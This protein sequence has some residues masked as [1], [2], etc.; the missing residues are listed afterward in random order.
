MSADRQVT[1]GSTDNFSR[2][3]FIR[4]VGRAGGAAAA[5]HTMAAMGLLPVPGA[6]AGAPAIAPGDGTKVLILGAGIA[7][8]V[9]AYE[10]GKLGYQCRILEARGRAG[11]RNWSLRGG[12]KVE[13]TDSTQSVTWDE[14]T[15]MYFNPGP[16]RLPN[17]HQGILS[18]CRE[19]GVPVEVMINDNR[20]AYFQDDNV[21]GG[22]RL[23]ARQVVNDSRGFVAELAAKAINR[24][25][26][27][28]PISTEDKEALRA[29]LKQ[30]GAL[31]KDLVYRGSGRAGYTVPPGAGDQSGK[32]NEPIDLRQLLIS[33][34]WRD[35]RDGVVAGPMLFGEMWH[36]Q[37]TMMQPIGGMGRIGEAFA[38]RL[39]SVITCNA[40]VQQIRKTGEGVRVVWRD[41]VTGAESIAEAPHLICTIPLPVLRKIDADF[42]PDVA[43][44]LYG[45]DYV[46]AG[47]IA[48]QAERRF[49]ELDDNIYG[50]I[51]WTSRDITQMW[52]PS[53]DLH[54]Q[55]GILVGAYVWSAD[56][57]KAF[58][59]KSPAQRIADAI[60]DGEYI[61]PGYAKLVGQ[62]VSVSW[63]K[64]PFSMGGWA[65]W[66]PDGRKGAYRTLLKGDGPI[67]FAGEHMSYVTGWQE[68][69]VRSAHLVMEEI[70]RRVQ[71]KR[72]TSSAPRTELE[73]PGMNRRN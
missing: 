40:E 2:R 35:K 36:H 4:L 1:K 46:Q 47:K 44:A 27:D 18:Y 48:F 49:W 61:H 23:R 63:A 73:L 34:F 66:K 26:L 67:L 38:R 33:D 3:R 29:L 72:A 11:G 39:G 31:D 12:D 51:S 5:Y 16:A 14:G 37:A 22:K 8:M 59:A 62:G 43:K 68:G 32:P 42:S 65:E 13:E 55:K 53:A 52:Y 6:Y 71:E 19:L 57:C 28:D 24:E 58:A 7:G 50:G 64:I 25:T 15:N 30:F 70:G 9:A 45:V 41:R 56:I 21:Y 60:V 10:L 69:A 17:H 20:S 54:H